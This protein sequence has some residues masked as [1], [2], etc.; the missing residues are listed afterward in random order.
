MDLMPEAHV[1]FLHDL[2]S[3]GVEPG[4]IYDIGA[5]VLHW[6]TQAVKVWPQAEFHVLEAMST[7]EFLYKEHDL[8]YHLGVISN[9]DRRTV[10]FWQNDWNP[11]GN[12][13]Y[14]ENAQFS[15]QVDVLYTQNHKRHMQAR[16]LDSVIWEKQWPWPDLIKMD[17]QGGEWD[18][19]QGMP[20]T[21]VHVNH[22]ILELQQ[23]EYN[24]GAPLADQ[25]IDWL[26]CQG[27]ECVAP[28]FCDAGPDADYYFRRTS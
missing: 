10:T 21:L 20:H 8:P 18:I 7:A 25:V 22:L 15:P 5:C 16:S 24:Q 17:V 13:Y 14:R 3:Q 12:S 2:K 4:V 1:Q 28:K 27:F 9:S 26:A 19:L 11:G 6:Y 23:V